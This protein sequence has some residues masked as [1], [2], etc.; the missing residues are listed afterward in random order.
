MFVTCLQECVYS[1]CWH[2]FM[3]TVFT[4]WGGGLDPKRGARATA[5]TMEVVH[6][7]GCYPKWVAS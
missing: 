6:R 1:A 4:S 3:V 7:M 2:L 5:W